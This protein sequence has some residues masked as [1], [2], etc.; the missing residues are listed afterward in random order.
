MANGEADRHAFKTQLL[1]TENVLQFYCRYR[2]H[3]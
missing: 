1:E 3:E 2:A